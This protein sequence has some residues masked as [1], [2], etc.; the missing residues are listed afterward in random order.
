[1]ATEAIYG[2]RLPRMPQT[3]GWAPERL[4]VLPILSIHIRPVGRANNL[5]SAAFLPAFV[6]GLVERPC[7]SG[8]D[9]QEP[10]EVVAVIEPGIA[11]ARG[12][13][14]KSCRTRRARR[15]SS[16]ASALQGAP[17]Q[18]VA[19]Q[20]D[21]RLEVRLHSFWAASASP[22]FSDFSGTNGIGPYSGVTLDSQGNLSPTGT[23]AYGG[24]NGM[25]TVFKI[26]AGT[27]NMTTIVSFNGTNG[28][29]PPQA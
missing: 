23:I 26:D 16:S 14:D 25:G 21:Q 28:S 6:P 19:C 22:F 7:G 8:D 15:S 3:R 13:S 2:I 1:M 17:S 27:T 20:S 4:R 5:S 9:H 10:P 11:A 29:N 18:S 12:P 24:A